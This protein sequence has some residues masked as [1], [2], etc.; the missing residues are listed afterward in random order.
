MIVTVQ[1]GGLRILN[2]KDNILIKPILIKNN[3]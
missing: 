2:N 3:V 1:L